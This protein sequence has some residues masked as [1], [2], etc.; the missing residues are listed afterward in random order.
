M[1]NFDIAPNRKGTGCFKW[2]FVDMSFKGENL[3]PM[4]VAD[5]DIKTPQIIIDGLKESMD[6][7]VYGYGT[8]TDKY[9]DSVIGW[10]KKRHNFHV[11]KEWIVTMQGVVPALRYGVQI[12]SQ[13]GDEIIVPTPIYP[14][15]FGAVKDFGRVLV[16]SSMVFE[17]G[18]FTFDF[19]DIESKINSKTKAIMLCSPH[20]PT[21]RIWDKD[22]LTKI[23]EICKK[24]DIY[25]IDDEIHNDLVFNNGHIVLGNISEDAL[26]RSI[27]C[28]A[29]SKTFNVAGIP[30]SNIIIKDEGIREKFRNMVNQSH[31]S[32]CSAIVEPMVCA[33]YDK[34]EE[35]L[36]ELLKYLKENAQYFVSR[37][38]KEIP[39]LKAYM[40]DSTYLLWVDFRGTGKSH[41]DIA[42]ILVDECHLAFNNGKDYGIE[43]E[44]FFRV[45]IACP[46]SYVED[47]VNRLKKAFA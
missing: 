27:I 31:S 38:E 21:G 23:C 10:L 26:N 3:L 4:W 29:P 39:S 42:N 34:C 22:E 15:F 12:L 47:A 7:V 14:P 46:R 41:D 20:N 30:V 16:T 24:H 25:I 6:D 13:E 18:R 17:N 45:N 1:Y 28:T 44:G 33:A 40:P 9:Y 37:I 2:D 32:V 5:M 36:E 35:W 43:G 8:L 11:E 19:N